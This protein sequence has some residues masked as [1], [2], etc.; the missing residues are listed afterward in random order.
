LG[1]KRLRGTEAVEAAIN[2]NLQQVKK[3]KQKIT[4]TVPKRGSKI[5]PTA[6]T[7]T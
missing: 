4:S 2:A 7:V 6:A 1:R 5:N 3:T